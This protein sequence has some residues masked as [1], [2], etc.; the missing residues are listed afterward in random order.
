MGER[1]MVWGGEG[2][3]GGMGREGKDNEFVVSLVY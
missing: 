1:G 3:M 2:G